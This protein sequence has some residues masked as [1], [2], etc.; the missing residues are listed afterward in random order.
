MRRSLAKV[1]AAALITLP[2]TAARPEPLDLDLTRL[3]PPSVSRARFATLTSELA[4]SLSSALLQPAST[5]GHSGF[6]IDMEAAYV[7]VHPGFADGSTWPTRS[8]APH[9]LLVPSVHVRKA[10]PW[11]FELGGRVIYLSESS[12]LATQLEAKW[13][14]VEGY[15][16]WPE[17]ALRAA[18]TQVFGQRDLSLGSGDFDLIVSKR[19]GVGAV[20]SLTPYVAARYGLVFASTGSMDFGPSAGARLQG[21]FP[22]LR[23]G[24][25]RSTLGLRMTAY[26]VSLAAEGTYFS[27]GSSGK[28]NP[29]NDDYPKFELKSSLGVAAKVGFEF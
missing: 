20:M 8:G 2:A 12:Y 9:E 25:Y 19:W 6:D 24:F 15:D 1:L 27:G 28:A 26:A 5:T 11:S 29:G 18:W 16:A 3:G 10:L 14:L 22:S 23:A 4:L 17:V 21:A 7:P 13:A